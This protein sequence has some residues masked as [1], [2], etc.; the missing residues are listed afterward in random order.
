MRTEGWNTVPG[1]PNHELDLTTIDNRFNMK[2]RKAR[3]IDSQVC[4]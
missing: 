3:Q 1:L 4:R 2:Q